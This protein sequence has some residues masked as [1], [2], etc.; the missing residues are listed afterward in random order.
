LMKRRNAA[1]RKGNAFVPRS[2]FRRSTQAHEGA[3]GAD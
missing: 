2:R 1:V 3:F